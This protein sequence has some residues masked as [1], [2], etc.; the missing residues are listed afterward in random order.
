MKKTDEGGFPPHL[1]TFHSSLFT[2]ISITNKKISYS[3]TFIKNISLQTAEN[4]IKYIGMGICVLKAFKN[5]INI[6]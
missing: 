2:S 5:I 1:F 3:P 6:K 4:V